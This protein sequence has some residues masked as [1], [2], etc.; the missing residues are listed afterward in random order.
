MNLTLTNA[1]V[2]AVVF[3]HGQ[4]NRQP[5]PKH[6]HYRTKHEVKV[7]DVAVV[8]VS[9]ELKFTTVVGIGIPPHVYQGRK[10]KWLVDV[11]DM[12]AYLFRLQEEQAIDAELTEINR[13]VEEANQLKNALAVLEDHPELKARYVE[14]QRRAK[15]LS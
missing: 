3:D 4:V 2:V 13:L 5:N 11:V 1:Q 7:G 9:N 8:E 15:E 12:E 10:L 14:L 6:Y